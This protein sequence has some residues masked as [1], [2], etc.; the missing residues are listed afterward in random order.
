MRL[1]TREPKPFRSPRYMSQETFALHQAAEATSG[2]QQGGGESEDKFS[3]CVCVCVRV[4]TC[5]CVHA[6]VH[7]EG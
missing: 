6:R 3:L 2:K 5:V 4:R 1:R 7:V